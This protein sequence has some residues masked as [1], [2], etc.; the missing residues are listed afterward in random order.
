[1]GEPAG[2]PAGAN[3]GVKEA[4]VGIDIPHSSQ[5]CLV[6][7]GG[8]NGDAAATE[9]GGEFGWSNREGFRT[10]SSKSQCFEALLAGQI[11]EF[12]AA[13]AT[14]IDEAQLAAAGEGKTCV[15]MS[16]Y[17][18]FG[19]GDEQTAGHSEVDDPLHCMERTFGR[20]RCLF[21]VQ[22]DDNVFADALDAENDA[23]LEAF[24]LARRRRLE[25]LPVRAE[26][27]MKD[28]IAAKA[29]IHA[30]GDGF[31][32]REFGHSTILEL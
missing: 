27:R 22:A 24:G 14:G 20:E 26:P 8:L 13:E 15:G 21:V 23:S 12:E 29:D 9:K 5:E 32:L 30:A 19:C 10:R 17:G 25:G 4:F 16:G 11:T 6:E 31:H 1:M 3:A 18:G 7:Q 2:T 28:A